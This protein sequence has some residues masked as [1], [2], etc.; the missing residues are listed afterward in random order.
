M[1][2]LGPIRRGVT[3]G[4][5]AVEPVVPNVSQRYR[6]TKGKVM[7]NS[8]RFLLLAVAGFVACVACD[9]NVNAQNTAFSATEVADFEDPWALAFLP[10]GRLLVT[11][12]AGELKLLDVDDGTLGEISGVPDV[13][14][15][16]QGGFGDVVLHPDFADNSLVYLSYSEP[17]GQAAVARAALRLDGAGGELQN[18]E[19]VWRQSEEIPRRGHFGQRIA[20]SGGYL[21][22]S[23]G[24]RQQGAPSQDMQENLGKIVRLNHDGTVPADNP[25][26]EEG[27]VTAQIWSL[28]HRNPLGLAFDDS[29]QLWNA[30]MGPQG[31]DELNRVERGAN[32]G[33]PIVSNGV[34]YGGGHIPDHDT[35]PEFNAPAVYWVPSISPSS[36]LFYDGDA[37]PAWKGNAFIGG[38]SSQSIR[39]IEFDASGRAEEAESFDMGVRVR[40]LAQGP[41]GAIWALEGGSR[42][43]N[44]RLYK[45]TPNR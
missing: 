33:W 25:F 20:F 15:A 37:F 8:N 41:D 31:G 5:D 9:S 22:I 45:L 43:G 35:R 6:L 2:V 1:S 32:Y 3:S 38:L 19:V 40:G 24:D 30:E 28:G 36:L 42:G 26:A 27:G 44:G 34:N 10:D 21:W 11:E 7:P 29:G 39:R 16:G 23:S 12:K 17:P 14:Y 13:A 18:L 4:G